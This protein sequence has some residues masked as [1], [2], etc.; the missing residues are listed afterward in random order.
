[1]TKSS[2]FAKGALAAAAGLMALGA[3]AA[4]SA[5]PYGPG[6]SNYDPC[7]RDAGNRGIAGA[8][9]GGAGGAVLGSQFAA[10]GHRSDGSLLGGVVGAIAGATVGKNTA[11]CTDGPPPAYSYRDAPPPPPPPPSAYYQPEPQA[12]GDADYAPPPPR[13]A[14]RET[15]WAYGRHGARLRVMEDRVGSDGCTVAESP[16]YMPD[17]RVDRRFVRVCPDDSGRYRVVD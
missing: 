17:G 2:T 15:V 11:A 7:R 16:V 1:M 8:L 14:E 12:Y 3:A 9:I 13:Y 10:R 6:Y 4:A 5:Q